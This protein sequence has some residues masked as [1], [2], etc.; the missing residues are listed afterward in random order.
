MHY[1]FDLQKQNQNLKAVS[2]FM[3]IFEKTAGVEN[4]LMLNNI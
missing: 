4:I 2:W 3:F 1:I